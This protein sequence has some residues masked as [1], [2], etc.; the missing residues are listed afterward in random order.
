VKIKQYTIFLYLLLLPVY[1][2]ILSPMCCLNL[3]EIDH[4]D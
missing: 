4:F 2:C 3:V 1:F